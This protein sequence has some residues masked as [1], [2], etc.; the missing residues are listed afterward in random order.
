MEQLHFAET[1]GYDPTESV[2]VDMEELQIDDKAELG[3]EVASNVSVVE[4]NASHHPYF[5]VFGRWSTEDSH[6]RT[7]V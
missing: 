1:T 3:R 5:L 6:V 7:H 4:V 2:G